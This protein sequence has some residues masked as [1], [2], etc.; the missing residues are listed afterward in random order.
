VI[1]RNTAVFAVMFEAI[2]NGNLQEQ[3][4]SSKLFQR[5]SSTICRLSTN[6]F[7]FAV[8]H[9]SVTKC[10]AVATRSLSVDNHFYILPFI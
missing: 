4:I 6:L 3:D 8:S 5:P 7:Q 2:G 9:C 10:Q 1:K